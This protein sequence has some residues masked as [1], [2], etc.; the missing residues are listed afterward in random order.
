MNDIG[1][2]SHSIKFNRFG[3]FR[4]EPLNHKFNFE[5]NKLNQHV[6]FNACN[7]LLCCLVTQ[8]ILSL[9]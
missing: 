6:E 8:I 1:I 7:I 4:N 5:Q 9:L 3:E 2:D